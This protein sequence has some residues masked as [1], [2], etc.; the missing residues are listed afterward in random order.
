MKLNLST[1]ADMSATVGLFLVGVGL[2][3]FSPSLALI[4]TGVLLV[5]LARV[6]AGT[7]QKGSA[8]PEPE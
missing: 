8:K 6:F 5:L 2:Y 1:S 7:E 4:Y 3:R